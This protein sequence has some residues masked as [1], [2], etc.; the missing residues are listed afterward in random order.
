[1]TQTMYTSYAKDVFIAMINNPKHLKDGATAEEIMEK[2]I[3][4][5]KIAKEA[6]KD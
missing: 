4:I 1:M 6:F 5:V 3:E 2:A